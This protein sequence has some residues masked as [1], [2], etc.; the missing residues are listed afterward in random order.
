MKL[1][2]PAL[3][4]QSILTYIIQFNFLHP[5][6][7]LVGYDPGLSVQSAM[8]VPRDMKLADSI[9]SAVANADYIR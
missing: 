6:R 1:Q 8:K 3:K 4:D 7:K 9:S 5:L 2:F